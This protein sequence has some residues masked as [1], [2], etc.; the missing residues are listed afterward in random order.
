MSNIFHS[1]IFRFIIVTLVFFAATSPII[2]LFGPFGNLKRAVVGA[3]MRSRHPQYITWLNNQEEL[4]E[5]LC[6]VKTTEQT[7]V[8]S[9]KPRTDSTLSL[10]KIE[11]T[12]F[13]GYLLEI[14]NPQRI[15]VATAEDI[16]E[17]GDTTSRIAKKNNAV[18]AI[19][20]G[21]F[22]DPNGTGTGR[23]PYGFIIHE[24]KYLLG[25][26][27]DDKERVDFVGMTRSGNLIAG[28]YNKKELHDL[29]VTEGLTFG[30][31]LIMNGKKVIRSGAGGWG[32]SPRSAIGQKKDGTMMFLVID[33]RQPGYS[34]GATLVDVQN[35]MYEKGAY[36]AA[37]LDG[38]SSTTLY[39]NG[40]VVNKPADLL[41]ERMIP[42][43]FIVK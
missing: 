25:Q 41:G 37:N 20:G 30:P 26:Q 8:L 39:Y 40:N 12:R 29:G 10:Q 27:V 7:Q 23:L 11:T 24:G 36:I 6:V 3:I 21:G 33:G 1:L 19:N 42:T 22:Y 2:V 28:N 16:Q 18:A 14:P 17:K 5:I 32:I 9:F 35:I 34:I 43:A 4:N 38:G 15:Q 31:P 13:V